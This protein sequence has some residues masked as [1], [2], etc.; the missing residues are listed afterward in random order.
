MLQVNESRVV[1]IC[2][3]YRMDSDLSLLNANSSL[4]PITIERHSYRLCFLFEIDELINLI[5][6]N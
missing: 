2:F 4:C 3:E 5:C 6:R 1:S